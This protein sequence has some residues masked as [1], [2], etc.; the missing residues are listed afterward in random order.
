MVRAPGQKAK[1]LLHCKRFVQTEY[2]SL[3]ADEYQSDVTIKNQHELESW[4][5]K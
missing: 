3:L 2:K 4:L 5:S 1:V